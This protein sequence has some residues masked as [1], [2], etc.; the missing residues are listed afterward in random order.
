MVLCTARGFISNWHLCQEN[1]AAQ[2]VEH[3]PVSKQHCAWSTES[4]ARKG[5][6]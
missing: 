3:K 4:R 1:E 5:S 2:V 6:L